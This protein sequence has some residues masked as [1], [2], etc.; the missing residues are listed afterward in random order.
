[1]QT[2]GFMGPAFFLTQLANI[3]TPAAAVACMCAS[4]GLDAFSQSG[5]YSNHQ[6][7]GPKYSGVLLGISNTAGVL[8]GVMGTYATGKIL[9]TG[10]WDDVWAVAVAFYIIGTVVWN[11]CATSERQSWG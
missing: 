1:M 2:V 7:I 8:A 9:Q 11:T 5:L 10:T 4:Q 6:D 3:D